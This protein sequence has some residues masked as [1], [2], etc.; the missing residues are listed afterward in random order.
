MWCSDFR[1]EGGGQNRTRGRCFVVPQSLGKA[2]SCA[3]SGMKNAVGP[4]RKKQGLGA[5]E[6]P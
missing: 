5:V 4:A 6:Q 2:L 3:N 1:S